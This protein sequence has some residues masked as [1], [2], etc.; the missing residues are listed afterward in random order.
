MKEKGCLVNREELIRVEE[1]LE[2]EKE[3][4]AAESQRAGELMAENN[5]LHGK[6]AERNAIILELEGAFSSAKKA[7][8]ELRDLQYRTEDKMDSLQEEIKLLSAMLYLA[9]DGHTVPL[10]PEN[11]KTITKAMR[12]GVEAEIDEGAREIRFKE[13]RG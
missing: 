5:S 1:L 4:V 13:G 9:L 12:Y 3:K 6:L 2:Q 11:I 8:D 7:L 10:S